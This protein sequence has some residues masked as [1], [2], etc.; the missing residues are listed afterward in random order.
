M[1]H[2]VLADEAGE[3]VDSCEPLVPGL[4]CAATRGLQIGQKLPY[5]I[6]RQ[7]RYVQ[8]I[9]RSVDS[10]GYK[11]N[12]KSQRI[13]VAELRVARE[14]ALSDKMLQKE[15]PDPIP[16]SGSLTH[17]DLPLHSVRTGSWLP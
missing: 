8:R 15:S 5:N 6:C 14:I 9:H 1:F 3:S 12:Q 10:A 13:S 16:E 7:V 17:G 2:A 4:R 11:W